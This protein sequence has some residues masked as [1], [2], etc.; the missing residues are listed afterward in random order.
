MNK[1]ILD[2]NKV[3]YIKSIKIKDQ[4]VGKQNKISIK[5]ETWQWGVI[6]A[7]DIHIHS[8]VHV[9]NVPGNFGTMTRE[10]ESKDRVDF[11]LSEI[12]TVNPD[13]DVNINISKDD[14]DD[15]TLKCTFEEIIGSD[16][17]IADHFLFSQK[18]GDNIDGILGAKNPWSGESADINMKLW[19]GLEW[20]GCSWEELKSRPE[21]F[22]YFGDSPIAHKPAYKH[23]NFMERKILR[24]EF[25]G[26]KIFRWYGR[27]EGWIDKIEYQFGN[28]ITFHKYDDPRAPVIFV[29][30]DY[31]ISIIYL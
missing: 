16:F 28:Q 10:P 8:S 25:D 2:E 30:S 15:T 31:E 13:T 17:M 7:G 6:K 21:E 3:Y 20:D 5:C 27:T 1:K 22:K 11:E 12:K 4:E 18:Y 9:F 23:L 19:Q 29:F 26:R 14:L 24:G